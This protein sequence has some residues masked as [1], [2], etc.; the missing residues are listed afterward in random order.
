MDPKN[1]AVNSIMEEFVDEF[2]E[3]VFCLYFSSIGITKAAKDWAKHDVE[4]DHQSW[5]GTGLPNNPEF[6]ARVNTIDCVRKC[7][8]DGLFSNMV[9]DPD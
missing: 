4:K 2:D 3:F 7:K 6:Y 5:I 9:A 8:K 1:E